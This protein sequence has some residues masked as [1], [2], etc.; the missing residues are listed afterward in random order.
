VEADPRQGRHRDLAGGK[1]YLGW[2]LD[3]ILRLP[4]IGG[5]SLSIS[6]IGTF[7]V[8]SVHLVAR[9]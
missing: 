9:S 1:L 7:L 5:P 3:A 6:F 4:L 2:L 8:F